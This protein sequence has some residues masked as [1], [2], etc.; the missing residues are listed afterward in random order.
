MF[1]RTTEFLWQEGHTAHATREEAEEEAEKMLGVYV[2]F[3][4]NVLAIPVIPGEKTES[5]R[6]PG[7]ENTYTIE[8]MMQDKKAL[9][10]GT[11]HFLGQNFAKASGI[12]FQ[13][14]SGSREFAWMSSWGVTTRLI[15][16]LIMVH[17][18]DD[19]LVLPPK[20]AANHL[21]IIPFFMGEDTKDEVL[22]FCEDLSQQL[23]PLIR[24]LVDKREMRAGEKGWDW[25][26]KGIPL[27][28]EIGKRE[29]DAGQFGLMRR[30]R[31][32]KEKELL[33]KEAIL[34]RIPQ[35]LEEIHE[36]LLQK[37]VTFRDENMVKI[38]S[39]DE[40]YAFFKG[41]EE[42]ISGGFALCHW[43]R[44]PAVE[45]KVKQELNVTIRCIPKD[46]P[47]EEGKC[48]FTGEKSFGRVIF[49][50]AY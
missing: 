14:K 40:F 23:K 49:A 34:E 3:A 10:A 46:L 47:K 19:G 42:G 20:V 5:E 43:N 6:F 36:N 41:N 16:A 24:V 31:P 13:S 17:S 32:H 30:D 8:A 48:L 21:V 37:A 44:D 45:E 28:L 15:G 12:E 26:K 35:V 29:I 11:S 38:D 2:D 39:I 33:T 18:D 9:Q 50:K 1:L 4:R 22:T 25:I 7:A 27:R